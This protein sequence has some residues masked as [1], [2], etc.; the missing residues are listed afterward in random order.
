MCKIWVFGHFSIRTPSI[1]KN[2]LV[3][4]GKSWSNL[5]TILYKTRCCEKMRE[6]LFALMYTN[7]VEFVWCL[8]FEAPIF[9][10]RNR[11]KRD[12]NCMISWLHNFCSIFFQVNHHLYWTNETILS[13]LCDAFQTLILFPPK[14][15][16]IDKQ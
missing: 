13:C 9:G 6:S 8:R 11:I 1:N 5:R 10:C 4:I 7:A 3:L 15:E 2:Y 12:I 14:K 16:K